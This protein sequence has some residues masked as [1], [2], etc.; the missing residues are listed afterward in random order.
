MTGSGATPVVMIASGNLTAGSISNANAAASSSGVLLGAT[1]TLNI[2]GGINTVSANGNSGSVFATGNVVAVTGLAGGPN[3][4][5]SIDVSNASGTGTAGNAFVAA[6]NTMTIGDWSSSTLNSGGQVTSYVTG[7]GRTAGNI[8]L[9]ATGQI[10]VSSVLAGGLSNA[11][12]ASITVASPTSSIVGSF[13]NRSTSGATVASFSTY[14]NDT[15]TGGAGGV[16]VGGPL[17]FQAGSVVLADATSAAGATAA[18]SL[19]LAAGSPPPAEIVSSNQGGASGAVT[20]TAANAASLNIG[21]IRTASPVGNGGNITIVNPGGSINLSG[22]V[23][24]STAQ[25]AAAKSGYIAMDA[26]TNITGAVTDLNSSATGTAAAGNVVLFSKNGDVSIRSINTSGVTAN[27]ANVAVFGRYVAIGGETF[28]GSGVSINA[29]ST[30]GTGGTVSLF[31]F[32]GSDTFVVGYSGTAPTPLNGTFGSIVASGATGGAV[33]IRDF[34]VASQLT[35]TS[36]TKINVAAAT[37]NGGSITLVSGNVLL[38]AD[39]L[40]A[41]SGTVGNGGT[42]RITAN[43]ANINGAITLNGDL[44][45][46]SNAG[47]GG[48]ISLDADQNITTRAVFNTSGTG[49]GTT[50]MVSEFAGINLQEY[51][52]DSV[53]GLAGTVTLTAATD[54]TLQQNS[55]A[56]STNGTGGTLVANAGRTISLVNA[57][58]ANSVNGKGG[59][60]TMIA[61]QDILTSGVISTNSTNGNG[62]TITGT[63]SRDVLIGKH[64]TSTSTAGTGGTITFTGARTVTLAETGN[65]SSVNGNGGTINLTATT[66]NLTTTGGILAN[67]VAGKGGTVNLKATAGS[68]FSDNGISA[69]SSTGNG[70]AVTITAGDAITATNYTGNGNLTTIDV[71]SGSATGGSVAMTALNAILVNSATGGQ[72]RANGANG[73]S[74]SMT[75][76]QSTISLTGP[77]SIKGDIQATGTGTDKVAGSITLS[78]FGL[79]TADTLNVNGFN[80]ASGGA[81]SVT[82]SNANVNGITNLRASGWADVAGG[83]D[84]AVIS[85]AG[86]ITVNATAGLINLQEITADAVGIGIG[87]G[88][89]GAVINL[90]ASGNIT[91]NNRFSAR[92]L[93]AANAGSATVTTSGGN[94]AFNSA[95]D[96]YADITSSRGYG[97]FLNATATTGTVTTTGAISADG[98][99]SNNF[100]GSLQISAG[101]NVSI[102]SSLSARGLQ[103]S[104]AGFATG[105]RIGLRSTGASV[106]LAPAA[107]LDV[108]SAGASAGGV[109]LAAGGAGG[110]NATSDVIAFGTGSG[111]LGGSVY[112]ISTA[113][114]LRLGSVDARGNGGARG[115]AVVLNSFT[116]MEV[117]SNTSVQGVAASGQAGGGYVS[118]NAGGGIAALAGGT[119][120]L[121]SSSSAGRGGSITIGS[122]GTNG[123]AS[124]ATSSINTSGALAGGNLQIVSLDPAGSPGAVT[125]GA[126]TATASADGGQGGSVSVA[127]RGAVTI[128]G[129]IN[130][131]NTSAVSTA[132]ARSGS[133]FLSSGTSLTHTGLLAHNAG[134]GSQSGT[135][136][137]VSSAAITGPAPVTA[138]GKTGTFAN[139][140]GPAA[141]NVSSGIY[142]V[143]IRPDALVNYNPQGFSSIVVNGSASLQI[144]TNGDSNLIAP[145]L[146]RSTID[147]RNGA[148]TNAATADAFS[149]ASSGN[150][151]VNGFINASGTTTGGAINITSLSGSVGVNGFLNADG[152]TTGGTVSVFAPNSSITF[153]G[154]SPTQRSVSASATVNAGS[155]QLL[156]G[157]GITIPQQV[158]ASSAGTAGNVSMSVTNGNIFFNGI[159]G[160]GTQRF[161]NARGGTGDGGTI[162]LLIGTSAQIGANGGVYATVGC[163]PPSPDYSFNSSSTSGNAGSIRVG[164]ISGPI[165]SNSTSINLVATSSTGNGGRITVDVGGN[166]THSAGWT[167]DSTGANGGNIGVYTGGEFNNGSGGL[168]ADAT[169]TTIANVAGNIVVT[170]SNG[171]I[172]TGYAYAEA[173]LFGGDIL[174][175]APNGPITLTTGRY[176]PDD[177]YASL[178]ARSDIQAGDVSFFAGGDVAIAAGIDVSS[179]RAAGNVLVRITTGNLVF[180]GMTQ[181]AGFGPSRFINAIGDAGNGGNV[182]VL[183]GQSQ[184]ANIANYN[185]AGVYY[186]C[187]GCFGGE[188]SI[189][190]SSNT[191]NAGQIKIQINAGLLGAL[192]P[193]Q[194]SLNLY[195][196]SGNSRAGNITVS[197]GGD[198][199]TSWLFSATGAA[200]GDVSITSGGDIVN[201]NSITVDAAPGRAGNVSILGD[202]VDLYSVSA[203]GFLSGT[204]QTFGGNVSITSTVGGI[205]LSNGIDATGAQRGGDITLTSASDITTWTL[206]TDSSGAGGNVNISIASGNLRL[207]SD[208]GILASG[209]N[210]GGGN[211]S[212]NIAQTTEIPAN[213]GYVGIFDPSAVSGAFN[214]NNPLIAST[215]SNANGGS[216]SINIASGR[217]G[218]F[219]GVAGKGNF[220]RLDTGSTRNSAGAISMAVAGDVSNSWSINSTGIAGGNVL[221]SSGGSFANAGNIIAD[222]GGTIFISSLN[223]LTV[224]GV[225][226]RG[227]ANTPGSIGMIASTGSL[228]SGQI[229]VSGTVGGQVQMVAGTGININTSA[230]AVNA[231]GS[232]TGGTILM[233]TLSPSANITF[234]TNNTLNADGSSGGGSIAVVSA[235]AIG[236]V[237]ANARAFGGGAIGGGIYLSQAASTNLVATSSVTGPG[238][239]GHI[240]LMSNGNVNGA[241][242]QSIGANTGIF[243]NV[244]S[245]AGA[246]LFTQANV[247]AGDNYRF[248]VLPSAVPEIFNLSTSTSYVMPA[249]SLTGFTSFN[250]GNVSFVTASRS[251]LAP[252]VTGSGAGVSVNSASGAGTAPI[253]FVA[254]GTFSSAGTIGNANAASSAAAIFITAR[255][256]INIAGGINA[257]SLAGNGAAASLLSAGNISASGASGGMVGSTVDLTAI[258]G[259]SGVLRALSGQALTIGNWTGTTLNSDGAIAT[260]STGATRTAGSVQLAAGSTLKVGNVL[261]GGVSNGNGAQ[262]SVSTP[263]QAYAGSLSVRSTSSAGPASL[264]TFA[265]DTGSGTARGILTGGTFTLAA[266]SVLMTDASIPGANNFSGAINIYLANGTGPTSVVTSNNSMNSGAVNIST[267]TAGSLTVGSVQTTAPLGS[268]ASVILSNAS[269][270]VTVTGNIRTTATTNGFSSGSIYLNAQTNI[271]G[272]GGLF[273]SATLD[274][275]PGNI[276]VVAKSGDVAISSVSTSGVNRAGGRILLMGNYVALTSE[277]SAGSNISADASSVTGNGGAITILPFSGTQTFVTGYG[278]T[279]PTPL[280]GTFGLLKASGNNGGSVTIRDFSP[281]AALNVANAAL[282]DVTGLVVGGSISLKSGTITV[283]AGTL[284]ADGGTGAGGSISLLGH[285]GNFNSTVNVAG[286]LQAS[287]GSITGGTIAVDATQAVFVNSATISSPGGVGSIVL[288]SERSTVTSTQ[289]SANSTTGNAGTITMNA[290]TNVI[291]N[292]AS[293]SSISG[294]AGTITMN[295]GTDVIANMTSA[296]SVSGIGGTINLVAAR[297]VTTTGLTTVDSNSNNGGIINMTAQRTVNVQ[298]A[299]SSGSVSKNGGTINLNARDI[300]TSAQVSANSTSGKGGTI[301]MVASNDVTTNANVFSRSVQGDGGAINITA[302]R[303]VNLN[304]LVSVSTTDGTA[305]TITVTATNNTLNSSGGLT[306]DSVNGRGGTIQLTATN[307]VINVT[308]GASA[309]SQNAQGGVV[310]MTAAGNVNASGYTANGNNTTI[311]VASAN[312]KG[313]DVILTSNTA[314]VI[315]QSP[316]GGLISANGANGGSVTI[317]ANTGLITLNG[318]GVEGRIQA[319][320]KGT[321]N[322]AGSITLSSSGLITADTLTVD[323]FDRASGGSITVTSTAANVNGIKFMRASGWANVAGAGDFVSISNGGRVTVNSTTGFIQVQEITADAVGIGIG[324]GSKGAVIN[325]SAAGNITIDNKLS[326][327]GLNAANAGSVTITSTTG[328]INFNSAVD[329]FADSSASRGY[330]GFLNATATAGAVNTTGAINADGVGLNNFGGSVQL[331]AGTNVNVTSSISARGLQGASTGY[332]TGGRIGLRSVA[333]A[334]VLAPAATLNVSSNG[335][336]AGGVSLSS[337]GAGG[338]NVASDILAFGSGTNNLGGSVFAISTAGPLT[339]GSIDAR[340]LSGGIGG[341]VVLTSQGQLTAGSL[342]SVQGISAAGDA[343]GGAVTV[344]SSSAI[345]PTAGSQLNINTSSTNGKGGAVTVLSNGNNGATSM[346]LG[347][348]TTTGS[349]G[350]GTVQIISLDAGERPVTVGAVT[351]QASGATAIGGSVAIATL[352]ALTVSAMIDTT[353]T[354]AAAMAPARSGS[355]FLSSGISLSH[356]GITAY[357]AG[358]G[359]ASG[360]AILVSAGSIA[361]PAPITAAGRSR[362]EANFT[363]PANINVSS[364]IYTVTIRPDAAISNYNPKGFGS[365]NVTG[366]AVLN[367]DTGGD[368]FLVAPLLSRSTIDIT[369]GTVTNGVTAD[370]FSMAASGN[371]T[372]RQNITASGTTSGGTINLT[373]LTGSVNVGVCCTGSFGFLAAN[374]GVTGGNINIVTPSGSIGFNGGSSS[375]DNLSATATSQAG[376]IQLLSG[377]GITFTRQINASSAGTAGNVNLTVTSGNIFFNGI[378]GPA[379]GVQRFIDARGGT[380]TGGNINVL[381]GTSVPNAGNAGV[382]VSVPCCPSNPEYSFNASSTNGNA[383]IIKVSTISGPVSGS[384]GIN[385]IAQSTNANG[386]NITLDI[387]GD[388]NANWTMDSTGI[389][390]GNISIYAGGQFNNNNSGVIA[391]GTGGG[392]TNKAGNVSVTSATGQIRMGYAAAEGN[393]FGGDIFMQAPNGP[394]TFT[395]GRNTPDGSS[396]SVAAR[397]AIVAGDVAIFAGGNVTVSTGIDVS[398]DRAAGNASIRITTGNLIFNG[399]GYNAR[400]NQYRFINAIGVAGNGGNV[401]VLIGQSQ[402]DVITNYNPAGI[403]YNCAGCFFGERSIN[404]GSTTGNAGSINI[405]INAGPLGAFAGV[406]ANSLS[407]LSGSG[408]SNAG[409]INMYV[410]GEVRTNW[411]IAANGANGGDITL[412]SGDVFNNTSDIQA[413]ASILHAGKVAI[414]ADSIVLNNVEARS[415][416]TSG[417]GGTV[418]MTS[419]VGSTSFYNINTD[420]PYQGGD[421]FLN[422][423]G[424]VRIDGRINT[425]STGAGGNVAIAI[426]NG[427]LRVNSNNDNGPIYTVGNQISGG[428]IA[429]SIAQTATVAANNGYLGIFDLAAVSGAF[430]GSNPAFDSSSTSGN[431]GSISINIAAGDLGYF[432]SNPAK[433]NTLRLVA[434]S[435]FNNAGGISLS[436]GGNAAINWQFAASGARGGNINLSSAGY[437]TN[438]AGNSLIQANGSAGNGG[439]VFANAGGNLSLGTVQVTSSSNT[440]LITPVA[441]SIFLQSTGGSVNTANLL[442]NGTNQAA[443]GQVTI[444]ANTGFNL[445]SVCCSTAIDASSQT[446]TGGTILIGVT[447]AGAGVSVAGSSLQLT[448]NGPTGGGTIGVVANGAI[449]NITATANG[450]GGGSLG[451]G[452]FVSQGAATNLVVTAQA[453]G[454][455]GN[456]QVVL[457]S[458]GQINGLSTVSTDAYTGRF[459]LVSTL[460]TLF[461][462]GHVVAGNNYRVT[463]GS[464]ALPTI[465]DLTTSQT[466]TLPAG[467]LTGFTSFSGASLTFVSG[468][469]RLVAPIITGAGAD[470]TLGSATGSGTSPVALFAGGNLSITGSI[471]NNAAAQTAAILLGAAGNATISG[472]LNTVSSASSSGD[473]SALVGGLLSVTGN[474]SGTPNATID[475][476]AVSGSGGAVRLASGGALTIGQWAGQTLLSDGLV[477]THVTGAGRTA[478]QVVLSSGA[479]LKVGAVWAGGLSNGSGNQISIATPGNATVGSL[480]S[481]ST[482][483]ATTASFAT[484]ANDTGTGASKGIITGGMFTLLGGSVILADATYAGS[485]GQTFTSAI[486]LNLASGSLAPSMIVT[487]NL[488]AGAGAVSISTSSAGGLT[489]GQIRAVSSNDDS[490]SVSLSNSGGGITIADQILTTATGV[491]SNSAGNIFVNSLGSVSTG[492][493]RLNASATSSALAGTIAVQSKNADVQINSANVSAVSGTGGRILIGGKYV[494]VSGETAAGSGISLDASSINN[495]GGSLEVYPFSGTD[496]FVIQY[497]GT[498]PVPA[499]GMFGT[500]VAS[501]NR[502]GSITV[503]DFSP[504]ATMSV[505]NPAAINVAASATFG[506]NITLKS[507]TVT[508]AAGTL[509]ADGVANTGGSINIQGHRGNFASTVT[510]NGTLSATSTSSTSGTIVVD[511]SQAVFVNNATIA[512]AAGGGSI[513]ISSERANVTTNFLTS[514]SVTAQAGTITVSAGLD[515]VSQNTVSANATNAR[516]GTINFT[517][518]RDILAQQTVRSNSSTNFGGTINF[519]AGR[520]I[521]NTGIVTSNSTSSSGG[522]V[523]FN[524]AIINTNALVSTDSSTGN[525]GTVNFT[526]PSLTTN[527]TVSS[528][529]IGGNAGSV[530]LSSTNNITTN[531]SVLATSQQGNGGTINVNSTVEINLQGLT[532][533]STQTGNAGTI[534]VTAQNQDVFTSGNITADSIVGKGGTVNLTSSS[535]FI[536][537]TAGVSAISR[538]N[539]GGTIRYTANNFTNGSITASGYTANAND[540]TIDV[541]SQFARGGSVIFATANAINVQSP[542][543]GLIRADGFYGG[544]VNLSSSNSTITMGGAVRGGI[545]AVGNGVNGFGG[546]I[547]TS[548]SLLTSAGTVTVDGINRASAGSIT[549]TSVNSNIEVFNLKASGWSNMPVSTGD[550]QSTSNAGSITINTPAGAVIIDKVT[551]N[552]VGIS[553]GLG[554]RGGTVAFN[555]SGNININELS[556]SGFNAGNAGSAVLTS[557]LGNIVL[558]GPVSLSGDATASRGFGGFLNVTATV[559][560]I[561]TASS[562][563]ADGVGAGQKAGTVLLTSA[564]TYTTNFNITARGLQGSVAGYADGGNVAIR[565][566]AGGINFTGGSRIDVSTGGGSVGGVALWAVGAAGVSHTQD[567]N[568]AASGTGKEAGSFFV[569]SAGPTALGS[570]D[571]RGISGARGGVVQITSTGNLQ[572]GSATGAT[573][574]NTSGNE[575]GSITLTSIGSIA[576]LGGGQLNLNA[577]ATTGPGGDIVV[578]AAGSTGTDSILLGS[579]NTS[580]LSG[581][582]VQV[583]SL[584]TMAITTGAISTNASSTGGAGG[585]IGIAGRGIVAVSGAI[586]TTNTSAVATAGSRSGSVFV[587][588]GYTGA[589]SSVSLGSVTAFNANGSASGNV[590]FVSS[591]AVGSISAPAPVVGAAGNFGKFEAVTGPANINITSGNANIVIKPSALSGY[592]PQGFSSISVTSTGTLNIDT[593]GDANMIAPILSLGA[594]TIVRPAGQCNQRRQP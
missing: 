570:V 50:T 527:A 274:A 535:S 339:L 320:G 34:S 409:N 391:D 107:T 41:Q 190:T 176:M 146:S 346:T 30:G 441:G 398:S 562:I 539:T 573:G 153:S 469:R 563:A 218:Y 285:R 29:S 455:G 208:N 222:G 541:S 310:R 315:I 413:N 394:V 237:I 544:S 250:V 330:G 425:S 131:T 583:A 164:V 584:G 343:G 86:R 224:G 68:V 201:T 316:T 424:D 372:V 129:A 205:S 22:G 492:T 182:D 465:T 402:V 291:S 551:A 550:V 62:G 141:I 420:A 267:A 556:V 240:V 185:P 432:G 169:G 576:S 407:L 317:T 376:N 334:V 356:S 81:I 401:D 582:S 163:C 429:I 411:Y 280:N 166:F 137:L 385:L 238:G 419:T 45:T 24:N 362:S 549:M 520:T 258:A 467:S 158:D 172:R 196:N 447:G 577:S 191:G 213:N 136:I 145:L 377:T 279:T 594:T 197:V 183:I 303:I 217:V 485:S 263:G 57:L 223:N 475:T 505:P 42:I 88:S 127:A 7:A 423:A 565:S 119:L 173:P 587:S 130:T 380:G 10:K 512:S 255:D 516:G 519:T 161:I 101:G 592:N 261:A 558:N 84:L 462:Q 417:F 418:R 59:S 268:G 367:F 421:V 350:G 481:R 431:A 75:S 434:G 21:L 207:T 235:G 225:F 557:S 397:G 453:T 20:L 17:T 443:G 200:G 276:M 536:N 370:A 412:G 445:T 77:G 353:N 168:I 247:N 540:S 508:I 33:V 48:L 44:N 373:S 503:R 256:S 450:T 440:A 564:S 347:N 193:N 534:N 262:V 72:V 102:A 8:S 16:I 454:V 61:A 580:G 194:N 138:A 241:A 495:T 466:Y 32:S 322:A 26:L 390:G 489:V 575:A 547:T 2:T 165:V 548:S 497:G 234:T 306:S 579:I 378:G 31:P 278:G 328:N 344:T 295:A 155:I 451:G 371:I 87:I 448:A 319:T 396:L 52:T 560:S 379:G 259:N 202:S 85:N 309:I 94:I 281:F 507:G 523:N 35:I 18:L 39:T 187:A 532:S 439:F 352:G 252:I 345:V 542:T 156:S 284:N 296:T 253:A 302:S 220:I 528:S 375:G 591:G 64:V 304:Q 318:P 553:S 494:N 335:A 473:V 25:G 160:I 43:R 480:V 554:S 300:L 506:G 490:G 91:V 324:I 333:G 529:T 581:G 384:Q 112:A 388:F 206:R 152:G 80:R 496:S 501:G 561:T 546:T 231:S 264:L 491:A 135:A 517:S 406:N 150:I 566:T 510:I 452:V 230:V 116:N 70:G 327:R 269:G 340:G 273:A 456:G 589:G 113:G 461:A 355:V 199:R 430:N 386:G 254:G 331:T 336:A 360:S 307:N 486:K 69:I 121:D 216:I 93:N 323:G 189:N 408:N 19:R 457:M 15:G 154:F 46:S 474:A 36:G 65:V 282:I 590:V 568:L 437:F 98:V 115:G 79:I 4:A 203:R 449:L 410:G 266:G 78:S 147:V 399:Q 325:L 123:V 92:G 338:I 243:P 157:T 504:F 381:I 458:N 270:G 586:S 383:G 321:D 537:T 53:S 555:S 369:S 171:Q 493:N 100:A 175:V 332:A 89:K 382:Y 521:N 67:S 209:T 403:Y 143:T 357:N 14:T 219:G 134:N 181:A 314:N 114:A 9:V 109:S 71:S 28:A 58:S 287:S 3:A 244:A 301:N 126:I 351:T 142:V 526:A 500:I 132:G 326:A 299:V 289:V 103:G 144:D 167:F 358:N 27:G 257:S 82:T 502:G 54:I 99:G 246:S 1:G 110:I 483:G 477:S 120:N 228:S 221:L 478:G 283:A 471:I 393:L 498:P 242:V 192:G 463:A 288:S 436:T 488:S 51:H 292:M 151:T 294:K 427:N 435:S 472:G 509:T 12:G 341:S 111:N 232:T 60:L 400:D 531:A 104:V 422:S 395:T 140:T 37:G 76:T 518:G 361:G 47:T 122:N 211:V 337:S 348:I 177:Q 275:T 184:V 38:Q 236:N 215:S 513:T 56:N 426:A 313:G 277:T 265:N 97:G 414:T 305:G 364:G 260:Y 293:A 124:I 251:L 74:V 128:S 464:L 416:G 585:S 499:N 297:D 245:L 229:D 204:D 312:A 49:V 249:G 188:R 298:G 133:V 212:I 226:A 271:N 588:S 198:I 559:G 179:D 442:A 525:G 148:V 248:T 543:G 511:A 389:N 210:L 572:V 415:T 23:I 96:L 433:S 470:I 95:V 569:Q 170:S 63:A 476:S 117:G 359:S 404:T 374:G 40:T 106:T 311:D 180:N 522:A 125:T 186:S 524:A 83:G 118:I 365:V 538:D 11:N 487:N 349:T 149:L 239:A 460:G 482:T 368:S 73:G 545:S 329:I 178:S 66:A 530:N 515:V 6:R 214:G 272:I 533:V 468:S 5:A 105:G 286:A 90:T 195:S 308:A 174:M 363:G 162:N 13:V 593:G 55:S 438:N 159:G 290:G 459:P 574:I 233:A 571:A 484:Y 578:T 514:D 428:N 354:N 227:S 342:T 387:G 392:L 444:L 446:Q 405:Q 366:T 139:Y 567:L 479:D 108:S 552:S